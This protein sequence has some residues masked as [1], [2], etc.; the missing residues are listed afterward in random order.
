MLFDHRYLWGAVRYVL[1]VVMMLDVEFRRA[2][3]RHGA[4]YCRGMLIGLVI[5]MQFVMAFCAWDRI[6]RRRLRTQGDKTRAI[7]LR[8]VLILL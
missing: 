7:T 8:L 6:L 5:L 2:Q 4:L 1:F 3:G